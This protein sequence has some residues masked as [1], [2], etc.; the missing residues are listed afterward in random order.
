MDN[1]YCAA[2]VGHPAAGATELY[3]LC[4]RC[5]SG[6]GKCA[7]SKASEFLTYA[8]RSESLASI[9]ETSEHREILSEIAKAWMRLARAE[10]DVARQ[11]ALDN[12]TPLLR[13]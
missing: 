9:A 10:S 5:L 7:M 4:S 12:E 13:Q 11:A 8:K 2:N 3:G 1:F 6:W